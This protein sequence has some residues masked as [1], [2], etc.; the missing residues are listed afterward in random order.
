MSIYNIMQKIDSCIHSLSEKYDIV[1]IVDCDLHS[2]SWIDLWI[3]LKKLYQ[4][5]YKN[6]QRIII[7]SSYDYYKNLNHGIIL[8]SLQNIINEIDIPNFFIC[9][10]TT[11]KE[12]ENEYKFVLE[13][14]SYDSNPL[15]LYVCSGEFVRK[16]SKNIK[17][18]T[19]I[20]NFDKKTI[21]SLMS[22]SDKQKKLLFKNKNFCIAPWISM[23]IS[24]DSSVKPCCVYKESTGNLKNQSLKDIW[25]NKDYRKIRKKIINNVEVSGCETCHKTESYGKESLRQSLNREFLDHVKKV[26]Q[27]SNDGVLENFELVYLDSRFNNLCNLSCRMCD[28]NS[29]SSWH[30]PGVAM[31]LI[32]KS[33]PVFLS[34]SKYPGE[35]FEQIKDHINTVE[36]IY[37]AGGEPL[38]IDEFYQILE[39]LDKNKKHH[40]KLVYNTNLTKQSLK[41]KNI[42]EYW[43]NFKNISVGASLDGEYARGEYLRSGTVWNDVIEF[44]KKMISCRPDID[45]S[46]SATV[47]ILNCLHVVDFHKNWVEQKLIKP[48]DFNV[49]L[50]FAPEFLKIDNAPSSLKDKISKKYVQHLDWLRTIDKLGR[51]TAGF[52]SV[53]SQIDNNNNFDK[54][55]F[56][57]NIK[58]FDNYY[59]TDLLETFPE[60]IDL[61]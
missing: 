55:N 1:D 5:E 43:K 59:K 2:D 22:L 9:L 38:I 13:N 16:E 25:N 4:T 52:E 37:F 30:K 56:W 18:F 50:L 39:Y 45:F 36:K 23:M 21:N 6:N 11:N 41:N 20:Q 34:A 8:Q 53:L 60:L 58:M 19:K 15:H 26:D 31:G 44:R 28:E 17:P 14:Y 49:G 7:K 12:I 3:D 35:L 24:T 61:K 46:V 54:N 29:S 40:V 48:E 47:S 33:S 10:V 42:F 51:A 32:N 27:T 57:K